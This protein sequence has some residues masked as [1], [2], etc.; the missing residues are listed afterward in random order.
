MAEHSVRVAEEV[1]RDHKLAALLH[2]A[3]EA[4]LHDVPR[5]I[6]LDIIGYKHIADGVQ[7]AINIKFRLPLSYGFSIRQADDCLLATEARDL[8]IDTTDWLE[9]PEPLEDIIYP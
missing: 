5:P 8:G 6:K 2:D 3:H 9:L 4:Y 1:D 7:A